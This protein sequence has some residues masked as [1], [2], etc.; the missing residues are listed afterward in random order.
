MYMAV[1]LVHGKQK[2]EDGWEFEAGLGMNRV[3]SVSKQNVLFVYFLKLLFY[4]FIYAYNLAKQENYDQPYYPGTPFSV[5]GF[6]DIHSIKYKL[7][8]SL[9]TTR[10]VGYPPMTVMLLLHCK[11]ILPGNLVYLHARSN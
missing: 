11:H 4:S 9:H 6:D 10:L 1:I 5:T 8:P 7:L 2:Q 3:I